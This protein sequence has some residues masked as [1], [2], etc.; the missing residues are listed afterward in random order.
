MGPAPY[1]F[2]H[3]VAK[4]EKKNEIIPIQAEYK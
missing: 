1:N 3:I 2:D 4:M